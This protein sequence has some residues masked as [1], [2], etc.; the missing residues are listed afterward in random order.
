MALYAAQ[1]S[2]TATAAAITVDAKYLGYDLVTIQAKASNV[3][4]AYIGDATSQPIELSAG[5]SIDINPANSLSEIRVK[6]SEASGDKLNLLFQ[7]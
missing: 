4:T 1:V 2:L 7:A 3:G 6:S 5:D